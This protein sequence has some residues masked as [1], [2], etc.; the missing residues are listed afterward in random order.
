MVAVDL[1]VASLLIRTVM[2]D[3]I[4]PG[5]VGFGRR[6]EVLGIFQQRLDIAAEVSLIA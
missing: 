6:E 3:N 4:F 5:S 2:K 1:G